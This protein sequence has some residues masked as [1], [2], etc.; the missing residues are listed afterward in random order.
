MAELAAGSSRPKKLRREGG[1]TG[2]SGK[3]EKGRQVAYDK[4]TNIDAAAGTKAQ[5][6]TQPA[7][8]LQEAG[9]APPVHPSDESQVLSLLA[10]LVQEY[11]Y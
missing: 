2:D 3:K 9:G 1:H 10:L 7:L 4:S 5:T 6:L 8:R 11:K